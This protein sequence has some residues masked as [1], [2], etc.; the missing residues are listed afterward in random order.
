MVHCGYEP[1]AVSDTL[2]H[3]FKALKIA[4]YGV[5]TEKPMVKEISL[6]GQRKAEYVFENVVNDALKN[7]NLR[8]TTLG[9]NRGHAA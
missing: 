3:P 1:T 8:Q 7:E 5:N 6:L 4:L 9:N 2:N